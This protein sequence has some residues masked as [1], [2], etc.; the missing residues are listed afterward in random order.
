M[1]SAL[2]VF[3]PWNPKNK[4]IDDAT[5]CNILKTYGVTKLPPKP[6]LF[7]RA[8]V[9]KSYVD[10]SEEWS[11]VENK[12]EQKL[13]ERPPDCLPLQDADNEE[14]EFAG[15]SLLGCVVAMFCTN[16][17]PEGARGS[18]HVYVHGLSIITCWGCWPRR[19]GSSRGLL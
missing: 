8:C 11:A 19:W 16:D 1:E 9:H 18:L 12:E 3:N 15:D 2:K 7:R 5:I 14:G 4:C 10:R 17:M 6:D 13:V